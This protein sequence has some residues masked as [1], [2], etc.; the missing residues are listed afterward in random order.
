MML[1]AN[2]INVVNNSHR[3]LWHLIVSKHEEKS[4][5]VGQRTQEL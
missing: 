1:D 2:T 4:G 5:K 3:I